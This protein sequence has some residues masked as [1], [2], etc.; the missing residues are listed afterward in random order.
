M[1]LRV[2]GQYPPREKV[3]HNGKFSNFYLLLF[4]ENIMDVVQI[5]QDLT[6]SVCVCVCVCMC[7]CARDKEIPL[8]V[9]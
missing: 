6:L 2:I 9:I 3:V 5:L 1:L 7:A 8:K 4:I